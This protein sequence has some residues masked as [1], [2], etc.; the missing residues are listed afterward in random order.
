[1]DII[2]IAVVALLASGLTLFSGFGLGT[3]LMPIIAIFF[4]V[5]VAIAVTALVHFLNN[6]F[7]VGLLGH[8]ADKSVVIA[9][10]IPAII[11]AVLGALVLSWLSGAQTIFSYTLLGHMF[12]VSLVKFVIGLVILAFVLIELLP[13]ISK[14]ALDKKYLPL[15]GM[16]SGFFGGLSGHQGVFRSMFLIKAGLT[17]EAFV[18]T[19]VLLALMVDMARMMIYGMHI[20]TTS[21]PFQLIATA[22]LAAFL[23]AYLGTKLLKKVTIKSVQNTVSILLAFVALGMMAGFV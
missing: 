7:K 9:F 8:K 11:F 23:G 14:V 12:E 17:K 4:P 19:G 3:L 5:D 22:T 2:I 1:M 18:A 16:L 20:T 15:G 6:C 10:G 13:A 21:V